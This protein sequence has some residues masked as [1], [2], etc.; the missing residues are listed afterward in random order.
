V[1]NPKSEVLNAR[2]QHLAQKAMP[3]EWIGGPQSTVTFP[4]LTLEVHSF[5]D[6][7][8]WLTSALSEESRRNYRSNSAVPTRLPSSLISFSADLPDL[9][10]LHRN[11]N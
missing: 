7:R 3:A 2:E 11:K 8:E 4:L 5:L 10:P 1:V 9:L 6:R